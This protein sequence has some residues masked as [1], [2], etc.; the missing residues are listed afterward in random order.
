M[1]RLSSEDL[2]PPKQADLFFAE[3]FPAGIEYCSP[4]NPVFLV[5]LASIE[6]LNLRP[7]WLIRD[8]L[9][10]LH[11]FFAAHPRPKRLR[12]KIFIEESIAH[13]VPPA[14][15]PYA[16]TYRIFSKPRVAPAKSCLIFGMGFVDD[17][18]LSDLET[19]MRNPELAGIKNLQK[20]LYLPLRNPSSDE[21]FIFNY[22]SM[23]HNYLGENIT[24]VSWRQVKAQLDFS[25]YQIL[26]L[27]NRSVCADSYVLQLLLSRGGGLVESTPTAGR[28]F[29]LSRFHG[30]IFRESIH[31]R[32]QTPGSVQR[33]DRRWNELFQSWQRD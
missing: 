14:W 18:S 26:Q 29:S 30:I 8:G 20:F 9:V 27:S 11:H 24:A 3:I 16:G 22:I 32:L 12:T 6:T 33:T 13:V 28:A 1:L 4:V 15:H 7:H 10:A 23:L 25:D 19:Q 2:P 17:H 21:T 5:Q 31:P